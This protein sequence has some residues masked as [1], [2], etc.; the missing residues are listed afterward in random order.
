MSRDR[1]ASIRSSLRLRDGHNRLASIRSSLRNSG[2]GTTDSH[3]SVRPSQTRGWAQQ[4]RINPFVPHRLR[5]GH[6]RLASIRSALTDSGMSRDRLALLCSSLKN[7][8]IKRRNGHY[9]HSKICQ[10]NP[11][12]FIAF[13]FSYGENCPRIGFKLLE[14]LRNTR[15]PNS[16]LFLWRPL[17]AFQKLLK[18]VNKCTEEGGDYFELK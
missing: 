3:Q 10:H 1:L 2:M 14:T 6:N 5:D 18:Q 16:M 13:F 12:F 4:T 17:L 9:H 8:G 7:S 11:N 15:R